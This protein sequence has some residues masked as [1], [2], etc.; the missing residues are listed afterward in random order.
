M[1]KVKIALLVLIATVFILPACKKGADDPFISFRSR[2][3]RMEGNWILTAIS[4]TN[5][6]YG[7]TNTTT[8]VSYNGTSYTSTTT[9]SAAITITG[10]Y[11]MVIKKQGVITYSSSMTQGGGAEVVTGTGEWY[12][13]NSD[14]NKEY[15][16]VDGAGANGF[17]SG[18][19]VYYV[20][21]CSHD[22]MI[23][24]ANTGNI[25]NGN[26]ST[27]NFTYTFTRQ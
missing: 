11:T 5:I 6:S 24:E 19:G 9:G 27:D 20:D 22:T 7:N 4:G 2:D 3:E 25:Q 8:T 26:G 16:Y 13:A 10:T 17:F 14:K 23:L 21:R 1:S 12:W 15:F 18:G